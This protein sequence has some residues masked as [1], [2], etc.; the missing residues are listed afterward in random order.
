MSYKQHSF[1]VA[2]RKVTIKSRPKTH[3]GNLVGYGVD[4]NGKHF[5]IFNELYRVEA[6][7][8]AYA[9]W[10]KTQPAPR[11]CIVCGDDFIPATRYQNTCSSECRVH[12]RVWS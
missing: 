9:K 10:V 8:K 6:E 12:Q 4:I 5:D 3:L 2:G 11:T 7:N 1:T